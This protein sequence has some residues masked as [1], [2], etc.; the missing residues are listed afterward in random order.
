MNSE[1]NETHIAIFNGNII[2]R[3][4]IN[5]KWFFSVINKNDNFYKLEIAQNIEMFPSDPLGSLDDFFYS[6]LIRLGGNV[7]E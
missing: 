2:R 5:E 6:S 7:H 4:L 1:D 3:K